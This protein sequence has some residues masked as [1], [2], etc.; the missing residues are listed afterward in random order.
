MSEA[1]IEK[2]RRIIKEAVDLSSRIR[3]LIREKDL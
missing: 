2:L 1:D 3:V